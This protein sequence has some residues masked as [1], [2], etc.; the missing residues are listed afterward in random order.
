MSLSNGAAGA[1]ADEIRE[2]MEEP[3]GG[4]NHGRTAVDDPHLDERATR[5]IGLGVEDGQERDVL[6]GGGWT[7]IPGVGGARQAAGM[8]AH[9]GV[10]HPHEYVDNDVLRAKVEEAFGFTVEEV[11]S[12]YR[13][14]RLTPEQGELRS[15]IDARLLALSRAGANMLALAR[16]FGLPIKPARHGGN[17][18]V[19]DNALTRARNSA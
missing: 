10:L 11:R 19:L 9:R 13:Q 14:G 3:A 6:N 15:R 18:R 4:H 16:V 17:C 2:L 1:T 5:F 12:V 7:L 8:T